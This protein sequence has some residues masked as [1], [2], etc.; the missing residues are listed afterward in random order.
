MRVCVCACVC[1]RVCVR[2]RA[3][4]C[5]YAT[6]YLPCL[7]VPPDSENYPHMRTL[8]LFDTREFLNVL[9]L[10]S[11]PTAQGAGVAPPSIMSSLSCCSPLRSLSLMWQ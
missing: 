5:V 3:C 2:V 1:V 9:T 10:V 8:L 7:S 4:V 11:R 6:L